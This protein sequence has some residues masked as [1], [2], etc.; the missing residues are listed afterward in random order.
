MQT[1]DFGWLGC[2]SLGSALIKKKKMDHSGEGCYQCGRLCIFGGKGYMGNLC[3]SPEFCCEFNAAPK[4]T[5]YYKEKRLFD[6][7]WLIKS[8]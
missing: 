7:I 2:I 3:T 5:C 4:T 8:I 1:M 6:T